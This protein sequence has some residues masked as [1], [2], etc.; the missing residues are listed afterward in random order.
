MFTESNILLLETGKIFV[1]LHA[2]CFSLVLYN[3]TKKLPRLL[4]LVKQRPRQSP[5]PQGPRMLVKRMND[6]MLGFREHS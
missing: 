1:C 4:V 5:L 6:G 3:F 2:T